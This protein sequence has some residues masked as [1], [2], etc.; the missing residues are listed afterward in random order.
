MSSGLHLGP[1]NAPD[2]PDINDGP[3]S[4]QGVGL[5]ELSRKPDIDH[6][7]ISRIV[8]EFSTSGVGF[9]GSG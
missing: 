9:V 5:S 7:L 4:G 8:M 1:D 2:K 3:L 6:G